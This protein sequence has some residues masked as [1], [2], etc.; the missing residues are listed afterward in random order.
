MASKA[1]MLPTEGRTDHHSN[2]DLGW[3]AL[4]PGRGLVDISGGLSAQGNADHAIPSALAHIKNF[5]TKLDKNDPDTV[6][7]WQSMLAT[8]ALRECFGFN[9]TIKTIALGAANASTL[10]QVI[11]DEL[12]EYKDAEWPKNPANNQYL[13]ELYVFC[14]NSKPFAMLIPGM[15]ICP[16][17]NYDKTDF[18][19]MPWYDTDNGRFASV[20]DHLGTVMGTLSVAAQELYSYLENLENSYNFYQP[21]SN[22]KKSILVPAGDNFPPPTI[23]PPVGGIS[24]NGIFVDDQRY[25]AVTN[26]CPPPPGAPSPVWSDKILVIFPQDKIYDQ[27][28]FQ[29]DFLNNS[30]TPMKI[31]NSCSHDRFVYI[32]PPVTLEVVKSIRD[33]HCKITNRRVDVSNDSITYS[34]NLEYPNGMITANQKTFPSTSIVYAADMPYISMWPNVNIPQWREYFVAVVNHDPAQPVTS[35]PDLEPFSHYRDMD[36]STRITGSYTGGADNVKFPDLD[37]SVICMDDDAKSCQYNCN[38]AFKNRNFKMLQSDVLPYALNFSYSEA[39]NSYTLGCWIIPKNRTIQ[40]S[41]VGNTSCI[42][43]DFGTTSTNTYIR[44]Q[45]DSNVPARSIN[46]PGK[47]LLDI[48][49]PYIACFGDMIDNSG[50]DFIQRYYLFGKGNNALGKIFTY[51]QLI[52]STDTKGNP[53]SMH[54]NIS[55]RFLDVD[56]SFLVE[57]DGDFTNSCIFS[58]LKFPAP[59]VAFGVI[60][61]A[62]VDFLSHILKS[63]LLDASLNAS[64]SVYIKFSYP[65]DMIRDKLSNDVN[66][67]SDYLCGI[68]GF[69]VSGNVYYETEAK[70]AGYY[71]MNV[72]GGVSGLSP[73]TGYAIIDIGGGT[74]DVSV[75]KDPNGGN[76]AQLIGEK[77]FKFAGDYLVRRSFV[78]T[79]TNKMEFKKLWQNTLTAAD[80]AV[81]NYDGYGIGKLGVAIPPTKYGSEAAKIDFILEHCPIDNCQLRM[82]EHEKF[83]SA[84]QIKYYA[85]ACAIAKYLKSLSDNGKIE[86]SDTFPFT[87]CF[88]GCGSKGL[89]LARDNMF[90]GNIKSIFKDVLGIN[91]NLKDPLTTD[92]REVAAGLTYIP[93]DD[94]AQAPA[95]VPVGVSVGVSP[96]EVLHTCIEKYKDI[97][98]IIKQY[99]RNDDLF[100][101]ITRNVDGDPSSPYAFI[102]LTVPSIHG[103]VLTEG[104]DDDIIDDLVALR[105]IDG[106]IDHYC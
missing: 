4:D 95:D 30:V 73:S 18:Q 69:N 15:V 62:R 98:D 19:N 80:R 9:V 91:I 11:L 78:R 6:N 37:V 53:E 50:A 51:G 88:A 23:I 89:S 82:K 27:N 48:F 64:P 93:V 105:L 35:D 99:N 96:S 44:P 22:F 86:Y 26:K 55:G 70:A 7:E 100:K 46:N 81:E 34:F 5:K 3:A 25:R 2:A 45:D 67:I 36:G 104:C 43:I 61:Q 90:M 20:A 71:Y 92:K 8:I 102:N 38:A 29:V 10:K 21:I 49:N 32:V 28:E 63:A 60:D 75:W 12:K 24:A 106:L 58:P 13:S 41:K 65:F 74:T 1:I 56:T 87:I 76:H 54:S 79:E 66:I 97:I 57:F 85:L 17:K 42:G 94:D 103:T 84:I 16:F 101:R 33:R 52:S 47:Y 83:T 31:T 14:L 77:S 72:P 68:S 39:G 40:Q 59:G